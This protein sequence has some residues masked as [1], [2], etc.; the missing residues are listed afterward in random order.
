MQIVIATQLQLVE[1]HCRSIASS[2]DCRYS[3]E[4]LQSTELAEQVVALKQAPVMLPT[5]AED[6]ERDHK[7][8]LLPSFT[9]EQVTE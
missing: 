9:Q 3:A 7:H 5:I 8:M 6:L 4:Y 1:Q 2:V